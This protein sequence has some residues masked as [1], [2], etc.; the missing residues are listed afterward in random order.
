MDLCD[1]DRIAGAIERRGKS[2][3]DRVF[4]QSEQAEAQRRP[5]PSR[6]FAGRFAAK[7]ACVKALGTGITDRVRWT[8]V[9]VVN[10]S[11]GRPTINL[12]GGALRRARRMGGAGRSINLHVSIS[13]E[14]GVAAAF[15]T[16]E[17][18]EST[19]RT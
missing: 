19:L 2:F 16:I 15:V 7:E 17:A 9:E 8:D 12:S 10:A 3:L 5:E 11:P 1:I 6:F 18:I 4:T 14:Q 13:H